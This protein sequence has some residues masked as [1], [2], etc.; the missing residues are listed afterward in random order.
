MKNAESLFHWQSGRY[1]AFLIG[2]PRISHWDCSSEQVSDS[3]ETLKNGPLIF[4][5]HFENAL[6]F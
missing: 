5:K 1:P 4:I 3:H 6:E 2:F